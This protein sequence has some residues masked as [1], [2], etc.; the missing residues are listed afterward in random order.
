MRVNA[1][2]LEEVVL[3]WG[4]CPWAERAIRDGQVRRRALVDERPDVATVLAVVDELAADPDAAI[5]LLIFPRCGLRSAAF[6]TFAEQVRRGDRA[7]TAPVFLIAAF[8]PFGAD[9]FRSPP[10]LVSFARRTPDPTLQLVRASRLDRLAP[11]ASDQV[12]R[13]NFAAVGARGAAVLDALLRD[14]RRD[15]DES[16]ARLGL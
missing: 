7:R 10:E 15:R 4:L 5:G 2:Y 3:G 13:Q 8:H 6:D 11:G 1:R 12:G 16:Y 9:R 14:I